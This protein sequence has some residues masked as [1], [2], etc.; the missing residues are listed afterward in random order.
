LIEQRLQEI[1]PTITIPY[2]DWS[3]DWAD[4]LKS[5]IFS[6]SLGL[7]V[8]IGPDGDCRYQRYFPQRH[9]LIRNYNP[10]QF[11]SFFPSPT[12]NS[13][14]QAAQSYNQ[15]RQRIEYVPHGLVHAATGGDNG[16]MTAM[17]S[18]NDPIFWLH[19]SNVDRLWWMWQ[20]KNSR[21]SRR[22]NGRTV[23]PLT[24]YGGRTMAGQSVSSSDILS[25]FGLAVSDTF[26]TENYCYSYA[27]FSLWTTTDPALK[28]PTRIK[29]SRRRLIPSPVPDN[30]I[31]IH[32]L[33]VENVRATETLFVEVMLAQLQ[34]EEP[35]KVTLDEYGNVAFDIVDTKAA[36]I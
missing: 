31:Q 15:V 3:Y 13:I 8:T 20:Q 36:S 21:P 28:E 12:I 29:S 35:D 4:P 33:N 32:G 11:S 5:P 14:I 16:D 25:P 1:E 34:H 18:V 17:H 19:H 23:N 9:C 24:A 10:R 2:W 26:Q 30:W 27:P 6:T 7:D 22:R